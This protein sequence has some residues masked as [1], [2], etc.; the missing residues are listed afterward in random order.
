M[1][2]RRHPDLPAVVDA[3]GG[4]WAV[5]VRRGSA[6]D[7]HAASADSISGP[8]VRRVVVREVDGPALVLGSTQQAEVLRPEVRAAA[9]AG[10]GPAV[11]RRRSGG[12]LVPLA[13]G[14][15]LWVDVVV[16]AGDPC[17]SD[18]AVHSAGRVGSWWSDAFRRLGAAPELVRTSDAPAGR[19]ADGTALG[20]VVCFAGIGPGEVELRTAAGTW[21]KSV[22]L[23]QRRTRHGAVLQCL[24]PRQWDHDAV[25]DAL[26]PAVV[27]PDTVAAL[28]DALRAGA[29]PGLGD[30]VDAVLNALLAELATR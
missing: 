1:S 13:P 22:G 30:Q 7:L 19:P 29:S 16:P 24:V 21:W 3:P 8:T 6:A 25:V 28:R 10:T 4:P 17:W 14:A 2:P 20:R 12:G 26:D 5:E 23:S 11:V 18:D 15:Q 27:G 9:E